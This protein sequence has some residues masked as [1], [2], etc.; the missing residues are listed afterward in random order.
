MLIIAGQAD[1]GLIGGGAARC[2]HS[3]AGNSFL[4]GR[5]RDEA[6]IEIA[7][8]GGE[9]AQCAYAH[10]IFHWPWIILARSHAFTV[11]PG[12]AADCSG[13]AGRMYSI[14][15]P[16]SRMKTLAAARG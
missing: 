15:C 5:R 8:P 14:N 7:R 9:F 16:H 12:V 2:N 4:C 6:R 1:L 3:M 11:A 10:A 13:L